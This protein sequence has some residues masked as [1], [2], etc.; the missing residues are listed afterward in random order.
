MKSELSFLLELALDD[1]VPKPIKERVVTRIREVERTIEGIRP[2]PQK[3]KGGTSSNPQIE[4]QAPSTQR[5]MAANPDLIPRPPV[6]VTPLAAS[7]L[8]DR[9]AKINAVINGQ[10]E[11]GAKF[12]RKF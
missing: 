12:P 9:Q 6:P 8:A 11:K 2:V 4:I 7:A 5:I 10:E 3:T 1:T